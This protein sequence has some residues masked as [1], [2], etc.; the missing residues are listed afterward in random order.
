MKHTRKNNRNIKTKEKRRDKHNTMHNSQEQQKIQSIKIFHR[1]TRHRRRT[2]PHPKNLSWFQTL[3]RLNLKLDGAFPKTLCASPWQLYKTGKK[4]RLDGKTQGNKP[5]P[6]PLHPN[7][8]ASLP[9]IQVAPPIPR[10][11]PQLLQYQILYLHQRKQTKQTRI[12]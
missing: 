1:I 4:H 2:T 6:I 5:M 3:L 8:F 10:W 9:E 7:R 12:K 11:T